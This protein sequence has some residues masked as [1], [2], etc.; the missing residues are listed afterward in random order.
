[1]NG[2]LVNPGSLG[3]L[4][5]ARSLEGTSEDRFCKIVVNVVRFD[6]RRYYFELKSFSLNENWF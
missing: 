3:F 1:M 5:T 6:E 4:S 2:Q